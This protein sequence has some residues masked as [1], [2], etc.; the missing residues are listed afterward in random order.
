VDARTLERA[1][2][3]LLALHRVSTLVAGQR[4][5]EDVMR[6]AL[7]GA[8]SLIGA[9][10]GAIFQ[11]D[12]EQQILSIHE[13]SGPYDGPMTTE[14]KIGEGVVGRAFNQQEPVIV[15]NYATSSLAIDLALKAGLQATLAVPISHGGRRFGVLA[16][17]A[18][19]EALMFGEDDAQLL[20]LFAGQVAVA[21]GNA[22]LNA[23]LERRL[24]RIR[25][26]NRLARHVS[27]SLNLDDALP[28]IAQAAV[29]LTGAGFAS[30]WLAD[31][32]ARRLRI[33]TVWGP[34]YIAKTVLFE[35]AFGQGLAGQVAVSREPLI[36]DDVFAADNV[37]HLERWREYGFKAALV[38][39]VL[40]EGKLLAVL[41]L[42]GRTPYRLDQADQD[43]LESFLTQAAVA[44]GNA[45]LYSALRRS[46]EQFQAILDHSPAT[47]VLKD[48]QR[49]YVVANQRWRDLFPVAEPGPIGQTDEQLFPALRA[50]QTR[51]NDLAVLEHGKTLEYEAL[52][53]RGGDAR[54]HL[55]TK[56]PVLDAQGVPFAVCTTSTDITERKRSENELAAAL[57]AQR[58]ANERLAAVSQAK[59]EIVSVVSHEFRT[60][61]TSIQGFSELIRDDDL[62]VIEMRDLA[63]D[64]NREAERLNRMINELL[65]LDRMESGQ[66][67]L[68]LE[69]VDLD[70]IVRD[71]VERR[72]AS[73]PRHTLR[74]DVDPDLP[75]LLADRDKLT[76]VVVNLLD[77]AIKY[78]PDGGDVAVCVRVEG[79]QACVRIRDQ[80]VGIPPEALDTIF[81]R[82][83]RVE[84]GAHRRIL[85]TGLGLPIVRQIVELHGG[86]VWVESELGQGS[87]F[88]VELPLAG[89]P[90][91]G[92]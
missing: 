21:L 73:A 71:V 63:A 37:A 49:R 80:G 7:R 50:I 2:E 27:T 55:V 64:I 61:L 36:V 62:S 20:E 45:S 12:A 3:R 24:E 78:S 51:Q 42:A 17:G 68:H 77:N 13:T 70:S 84:S 10:S 72:R 69:T 81:D 46:Q 14:V 29:E 89:P 57:A 85:G 5:I 76:Q 32:E 47:I 86:R 92:E 58:A 54:T 1:R 33:G 74:L 87:T 83:T 43:V 90:I 91:R 30:F 75:R 16:L 35:L 26:L 41:V 67:T 11:L 18:Y 79:L 65:D 39:P 40:H 56:F 28:Q 60:P 25:T 9:A 48:R 6:E 53:T 44:I 22:E 52:Y 38:L 4:Q 15:N 8:V 66:M 82:Y 23:Q 88:H 34:G 19:G 31:E 59:S